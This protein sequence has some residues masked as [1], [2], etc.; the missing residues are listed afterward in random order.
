MWE[1]EI[2]GSVSED[3]RHS[4]LE[5][6]GRCIYQRFIYSNIIHFTFYINAP[7]MLHRKKPSAKSRYWLVSPLPET[8]AANEGER[9]A[10]HR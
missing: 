9:V 8:A 7:Q 3:G 2:R 1:S 6:I 4:L 5:G 10:D